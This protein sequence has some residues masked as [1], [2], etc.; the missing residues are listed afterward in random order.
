MRR[1]A[2][3]LFASAVMPV[4]GQ[5]N[6]RA[7]IP[8]AR[9]SGAG[10]L[11]GSNFYCFGGATV[12]DFNNMTAWRY[13]IPTNQWFPIAAMPTSGVGNGGVNSI[14][15]AAIGTDIYVVGGYTGSTGLSRLLKYSTT[16][17]TWVTVTTDPLSTNIFSNAAISLAGK[18]YALG[19]NQGA[20]VV[21]R[22]CY[23][24]DPLAAAGSRWS[25]I[26][27]LNI[28]R[29]YACA[30]TDGVRIYAMGG[31]SGAGTELSSAEMWQPG[32]ASWTLLPNM[33][34]GRGG[35][36]AF[37]RFGRPYVVGGGFNAPVNTGEM[38][39]GS[40]WSSNLSLVNTSRTFAHDSTNRFFAKAGG[41][42]GGYSN[43]TEL[44]DLAT[45]VTAMTLTKGFF[46]AGNDPANLKFADDARVEIRPGP[47]LTTADRQ[48]SLTLDGAAS[49]A[50]A[51]LSVKVG[52]ECSATVSNVTQ[53]VEAY[54]W[55]NG[56][57]VQVDQRVLATTD[58]AVE[59]TLPAPLGRFVSNS[60]AVRLRLSHKA[61]G[62][63]L[64]FPWRALL[65]EVTWR[66]DFGS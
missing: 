47:V 52:L 18:F 61:G 49:S 24:Y 29:R 36:G 37:S 22:N 26:P 35:A 27:M 10:V 48:T 40:A 31:L 53:W 7:V 9:S 45:A 20:G 63:T 12:G 15:A 13:Y 1:L 39:D 28:A 50:T 21:S 16:G 54:N 44:L 17:N 59:L 64:I 23:V 5:W 2:A 4:S 57:W 55:V 60:G 66:I 25:S 6:V 33:S 14:D 41:W 30:M 3:I 19:G 51:P 42:N 32:D 46:M 34:R 62:P 43:I 8:E 58:A 65:D 56:T 38:Y 11:V